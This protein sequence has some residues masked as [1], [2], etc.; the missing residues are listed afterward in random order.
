MNL[1]YE[2]GNNK[3]NYEVCISVSRENGKITRKEIPKFQ[4]VTTIWWSIT[5][6]WIFKRWILTVQQEKMM[7]FDY[8][9]AYLRNISNKIL[10]RHFKKS[11]FSFSSY[12]QTDKKI[13]NVKE[14]P[15]RKTNSIFVF[16]KLLSAYEVLTRRNVI[17]ELLLHQ[18]NLK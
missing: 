1:G 11:N 7:D 15:R 13:N 2:P 9:E 5:E 8:C 17:I 16:S 10:L 6:M 12:L 4:N 3:Q 14:D 18:K